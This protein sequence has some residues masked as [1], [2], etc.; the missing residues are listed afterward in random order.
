VQT[1]LGPPFVDFSL[2][3]DP[4]HPSTSIVLLKQTTFVLF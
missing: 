2:D 1:I 4:H 3:N